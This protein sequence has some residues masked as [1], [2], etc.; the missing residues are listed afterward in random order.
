MLN[1]ISLPEFET[2]IDYVAETSLY[3]GV[4]VGAFSSGSAPTMASDVYNGE[5][6]AAF[7]S[8]SAPRASGA[9]SLGERTGAFSSGS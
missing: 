4:H 3:E 2:E 5:C 7:S 9:I 8:G 1:C 6:V